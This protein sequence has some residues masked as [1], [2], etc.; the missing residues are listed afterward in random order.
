LILAIITTLLVGTGAAAGWFASR[1]VTSPAQA[2]AEAIPPAPTVLTETVTSGRVSQSVTFDVKVQATFSVAVAAPAPSDGAVSVITRLPVKRGIQ[3]HTGDLVAEVSGRPV[4]LLP[5]AL[6]AYRTLSP[7]LSGPDVKQLQHAL[8]AANYFHGSADGV[9][10]PVTA[11]AVAALYEHHG[12]DAVTVGTDEVE[13][14][15]DAVEQARR[16][17]AEVPAGAKSSEER[18][19]VRDDLTKATAQLAIARAESGAQIPVGEVLFVSALPATVADVPVGVGKAPGEAL[20]TLNSGALVARGTPNAVDGGKVEIGDRVRL[21]LSPTGEMSGMV[22]AIEK[23]A[24]SEE[25]A[26]SQGGGLVFTVTPS[27]PI[28]A[29]S[30]GTSARAIVTTES[31]PKEGLVVPEAALSMNAAGDTAVITM[32]DDGAK[33]RVRVT[34]GFSGDGLVQVTPTR[35][36][37]L[38]VGDRVVVGVTR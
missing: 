28:P 14:A 16:A 9:Y 5:G 24:P 18:R 15:M 6:P 32:T 31:S 10:G 3:V 29:A 1:A 34:A 22:T 17:L 12:Y 26:D 38:A 23:V 25:D 33:V 27:K 20:L 37:A 7:G 4:I 11:A 21:L 35:P 2:V 13:A 19:F 8:S 36:D 30:T